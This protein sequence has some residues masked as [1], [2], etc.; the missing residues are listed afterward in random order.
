M[1]LPIHPYVYFATRYPFSSSQSS[2]MRICYTSSLYL[3]SEGKGILR[4]ETKTIQTVPGSFVYIP[5][6]QAHEWIADEQDPM[7]HVCCYFDWSYRDR[8][9]SFP[10]PSHICYDFSQ[11][12]QH[13]I[14]PSFQIAL[15]LHMKV[16]PIRVWNDWFETFYKANEFVSE[17]NFIRD[18]TIQRN[19]LEFMEYYLTY[20]LKN[21]DH[22]DPRIYRILDQLE[23]DLIYGKLKSLE[24]YYAA[25]NISRGYFFERF[26]KVTGLSPIQYINQ[27]RINRAKEELRNSNL[28]ITEIAEKHHFSSIHYF[29]RLFRT[30]TGYTP[31]QYR[32]LSD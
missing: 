1:N 30:V 6:G 16:E 20:A 18:L 2:R 31:K 11:L 21:E 10:A 17:R 13:L 7:V 9:A 28:S 4:T 12:Q 5:A 26:K 24:A 25:Q 15:P 32:E 27:F 23:Q 3:I 14:G 29:S 22:F 19:F 8:T